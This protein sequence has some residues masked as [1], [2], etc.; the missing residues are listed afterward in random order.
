MATKSAQVFNTLV[1][2][3]LSKV[4]VFKAQ[5]EAEVASGEINKQK[6]AV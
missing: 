2:A 5:I 4:E 6:V 3:E 1:Q